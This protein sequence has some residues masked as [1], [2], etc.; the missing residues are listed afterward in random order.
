MLFNSADE[1]GVPNRC[2]SQKDWHHAYGSSNVWRLLSLRWRRS[3]ED[4]TFAER[5]LVSGRF[6][7]NTLTPT[8]P[9]PVRHPCVSK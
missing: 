9:K 8:R 3:Y 1:Y 5:L 7:A 2:F 4:S 6:S